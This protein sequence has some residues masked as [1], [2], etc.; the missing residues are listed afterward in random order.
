MASVRAP[1]VPF[2]RW[3]R[4][5]VEKVD[6]LVGLLRRNIQKNLALDAVVLELRG[7]TK[8]GGTSG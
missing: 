1:A 6:E 3:L 8:N 2:E 7:C 4:R 5:A